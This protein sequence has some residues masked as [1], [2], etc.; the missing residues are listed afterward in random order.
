[1]NEIISLIVEALLR[2]NISLICLAHLFL[3]GRTLIHR[4]SC[5]R[6]LLTFIHDCIILFQ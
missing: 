3:Q 2:Y 4:P 6:I 5:N 1:M